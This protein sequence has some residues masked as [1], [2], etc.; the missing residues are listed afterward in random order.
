MSASVELWPNGV[1]SDGELL[2]PSS[3]FCWQCLDDLLETDWVYQTNNNDLWKFC[4]ATFQD[5][6][7]IP[8]NAI[9]EQIVLDVRA[10]RVYYMGGDYNG[11]GQIGIK[12]GSLHYLSGWTT[13]PYE[14]PKTDFSFDITNIGVAWTKAV[15][16]SMEAGLYLRCDTGSSFHIVRGYWLRCTVTYRVP[17][18]RGA[19][20]IGAIW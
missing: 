20:I 11:Y 9:I 4:Y 14:S 7:A 15:I 13:I 18:Q 3:G 5:T 6:T 16:N 19:Q 2:T 10:N 17:G 8:D 12:I 1:G